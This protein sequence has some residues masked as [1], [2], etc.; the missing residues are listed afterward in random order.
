V[1]AFSF[2]IVP[3]IPV[4]GY[5]IEALERTVV[6]RSGAAHTA[7]SPPTDPVVSQPESSHIFTAWFH[8]VDYAYHLTGA[9]APPRFESPAAPPEPRCWLGLR[10][11][12]VHY[13]PTQIPA[14]RPCYFLIVNPIHVELIEIFITD[15]PNFCMEW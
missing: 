5:P 12:A 8:T 14:S 3:A 6:G 13:S 1:F 11:R 9:S 2:F 4:T 15:R 10:H 7:A